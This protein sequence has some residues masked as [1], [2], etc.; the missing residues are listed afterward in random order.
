MVRTDRV[1]GVVVDFGFVNSFRN[2]AKWRRG[3]ARA[4]WMS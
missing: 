2:V 3:A 1:I 4:T